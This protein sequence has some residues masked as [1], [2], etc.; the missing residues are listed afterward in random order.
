METLLQLETMSLAKKGKSGW[1]TLERPDALNAVNNAA[2]IQ[3][4][5]LVLALG[6]DPDIR[7][8][9]VRGAGRAFCTGI[10]LKELA[11]DQIPMAYHRRWEKALRRI[12]VMEKIFVLGMHGYCLGGGL[13]LALA[14]DI[15]VATEGCRIGLPA[16]RESLIPGLSTWRLPR[17]IGLGRAKTMI[18]GGE[19][20]D[21]RQAWNIGLVDHLV[22]GESFFEQL[23]AVG[24]RYLETCSTGT[25]MSKLLLNRA[26]DL[27]F[28]AV[29]DDYEALQQ[30]AQYSLDAAAA[31][32]AFLDGKK[33]QWQ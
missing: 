10:D 1:I 15:R 25:R 11:A 13:Q 14:C 27:D 26:L 2:T 3:F 5:R 22:S 17:H 9:M 23:D 8:V 31:S 12:E 18:L 32:R 30:R 33:P 16:V 4:E 24:A 6:E 20:I 21:G 29:C 19:D 7:V 28:A